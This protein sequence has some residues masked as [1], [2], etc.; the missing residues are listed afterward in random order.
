MLILWSKYSKIELPNYSLT[1]HAFSIINLGR[2]TRD[3]IRFATPV[4][5]HNQYFLQNTAF[6]YSDEDDYGTNADR[7]G[8]SYATLARFII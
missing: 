3:I 6:L 7:E 4:G 8:A 2:G 5:Y 1:E